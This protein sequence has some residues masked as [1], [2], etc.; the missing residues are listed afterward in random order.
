M[1]PA[2]Q[3][4]PGGTGPGTH[5]LLASAR[6]RLADAAR[7]ANS[8]QTRYE[9]ARTALIQCGAVLAGTAGRTRESDEA[10]SLT[11]LRLSLDLDYDM[12]A[13]IRLWPARRY[14]PGISPST[15][16]LDSL[17]RLA[18]RALAAAL[19]R[20]GAGSNPRAA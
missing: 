9:T 5:A 14:Q 11:A 4:S 10:S 17:V 2:N 1:Q 13:P 3:D 16:E 12:L 8:P 15:G 6:S 19:L 18:E 7:E 20:T